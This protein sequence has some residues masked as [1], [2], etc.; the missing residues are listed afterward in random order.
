MLG[1]HQNLL[2]AV[3]ERSPDALVV[4]DAAGRIVAANVSAEAM[5]GYEHPELVGESIEVLIPEQFRFPHVR[6]RAGFMVDPR[7]RRPMGSGIGLSARRR[8]GSCFPVE[9]ALSSVQVEGRSFIIAAVRDITQLHHDARRNRLLLD[10][11][12]ELSGVFDRDELLRR[13]HDRLVNALPCDAVA[14]FSTE[15]EGRSHGLIGERGLPVDLAEEFLRGG[16]DHEALFGEVRQSHGPL[17]IDTIDQIPDALSEFILRFG[18]GSI[19]AVPLQKYHRHH[20]RLVA[21][22]FQGAPFGTDDVDLCMG[23]AY[24]L[25][26]ALAVSA[27]HRDLTEEAVVAGA[28][29][30]VGR[31]L[32]AIPERSPLLERLCQLGVELLD[33]DCVCALLHDKTGPAFVPVSHAGEPGVPPDMLGTLR[34]PVTDFG[35][36]YSG[37]IANEVVRVAPDSPPV[38]I[39]IRFGVKVALGVP[40]MRGGELTGV[41]LGGYNLRRPR[42]K[43]EH[44]RVARGLGQLASLALENTRL[45]DD[46]LVANRLKSEFIATVSHELR[47]PLHIILGF[48][49][50]LLDGEL[51]PVS[52]EQRDAIRRT[53]RAG[54]ALFDLIESMLLMSGVAAGRPAMDMRDVHLGTLLQEL[55]LEFGQTWPGGEVRVVWH[56]PAGLPPIH[57]D[58]EKLRVVLR[59]VVGNALKFTPSGSVSIG[60]GLR[61]GGV[62]VVVADSGIGIA[63]DV[64]PHIFEPF[65]QG[66]GSATR[67]YGGVGLGLFVA[68]RLLDLLK[69]TIGVHSKVGEGTTFR[70]FLPFDA[71]RP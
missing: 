32:L 61:D 68:R 10:V 41:L 27:L 26:L 14:I 44:L 58:P 20:G 16:L 63:P 24:E 37:L 5:F 50:L 17:L 28:L 54:R 56:V 57:T 53:E 15:A 29:A 25:S 22:R 62:E 64:L 39:G 31:E 30:R 67:R 71:S 51:G 69:G 8:D 21:L 48:T 45:L 60:A 47:T 1:V 40:I 34:L 9:I 18:I 52:L 36:L 46:L 42:I 49:D 12:R 3:F 55:R 35:D 13:A 7:R 59:N 11:A 66:D 2:D 38:G 4:S 33:V 70:I 23:V 43:D 6:H 65:R 19:L